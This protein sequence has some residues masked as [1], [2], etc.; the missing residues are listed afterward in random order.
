MA[1]DT[2]SMQELVDFEKTFNPGAAPAEPAAKSEAQTES[3]PAAQVPAEENPTAE[4]STADTG[5]SDGEVETSADSTTAPADDQ[6]ADD[7]ATG[8]TETATAIKPKTRGQLRIEE[9]IAGNKALKQQNEYLLGKLKPPAQPTTE[10][11]TTQ[12]PPAGAQPAATEE[13]APTLESF[14]FDTAKW[15]EAMT[16]YTDR[17]IAAGVQAKAQ[18]Q[19]REQEQQAEQSARELFTTRMN[20]FAAKTADFQV[21]VENP[22]LPRLSPGAARVLVHSETG[23]QVLYHLAKNPDVLTRIAR[24]APEQQA[25]AIG[26]L[27]A[28][29][30]AKPAQQKTTNRISSAPKPPTPTSGRGNTP[31]VDPAKMTTKEWIEWDRQQTLKDRAAK[32]GH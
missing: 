7:A 31:G 2:F 8:E 19:Q 30:S 29:L 17:R 32:R 5:E 18:V 11:Q 28:E 25:A 27:E 23:P 9:L 24:Q 10:S 6:E 3:Q 1:N 20:S 13:A 16:A 14:D 26:R 15:Q 21:L 22:N 4:S 12:E